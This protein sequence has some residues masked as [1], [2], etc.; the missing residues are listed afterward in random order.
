MARRDSRGHP[1]RP[2][3]LTPATHDA[4][5]KAVA[6]GNWLTV[7]AETN[8]IARSTVYGWTARGQA[9]ADLRDQGKPIPPAELPFLRFLDDL[10]RARARAEDK[11]RA[12]IDLCIEGGFVIAETPVVAKDGSLCYDE[13]GRIL[14]ARKYAPPDGRLGLEVLART[15]PDRWSRTAERPLELT[16][17]VADADDEGLPSGPNSPAPRIHARLRELAAAHGVTLPSAVAAAAVS[18]GRVLE[19]MIVERRPA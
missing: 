5:V 19:G 1:G 15:S 11:I 4:I 17:T 6:A 3:A 10:V 8:G 9:A 2:T 18:D 13:D 16:A 12:T 7:A 14:M